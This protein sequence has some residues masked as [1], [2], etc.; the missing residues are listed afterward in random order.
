MKLYQL[1]IHHIGRR[2]IGMGLALLLLSLAACANAA[3][4]TS[5]SDNSGNLNVNTLIGITPS[6][7]FEPVT[8]GA[9]VS[10]PSPTQGDN[11]T[12]YGVIR[13]HDYSTAGPPQAPKSPVQVSIT[14][15][16]IGAPPANTD[17]TGM[18][19]FIIKAS[20]DPQHPV[21]IAL[22]ASYSGQILRTTTFYT[23]LPTSYPT[24]TPKL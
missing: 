10:N 16:G 14:G 23:V 15:S 3:P 2:G 7:T 22:T 6:S 1:G 17:A 18:V 11:I 19:A 5:V 9:W 8:I 20:G 12:V 21:E 13:V 24:A 4:S